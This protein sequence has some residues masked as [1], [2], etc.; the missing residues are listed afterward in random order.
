MKI[1]FVNYGFFGNNSYYHIEGFA[2]H[3]S[4]RGH[5]VGVIADGA[6]SESLPGVAMGSFEQAARGGLD[7]GL[8]ALLGDCETILHAWTPREPVR[9]FVEPLA[10]AGLRYV[11]HLEDDELLVTASQL[12]VAAGALMRMTPAQVDARLPNHLTHPHKLQGFLGRASGITVIVEPLLK[13][14][15]PASPVHLLE[16]G[17][18]SAMFAPKLDPQERTHRRKELGIDPE[19]VLLVYHGNVHEAVQRDI[20]SLY[21]A[22]KILRRQ[23]RDVRLL[24]TGM[25]ECVTSTSTSYRMSSGVTH[26][27]RLPRAELPALLDLADIYVQSGWLNGFNLARF[28]SKLPEFFAM[29]RPVVLP[30][31]NLGLQVRDGH[32]AIVLQ[33]GGAAEIVR[34]VERLI[35]DPDLA[36]DMGQA[37]RQ[38]ALAQLSWEEKT[39]GLEAFYASLASEG[40][41]DHRPP[42]GSPGSET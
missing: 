36:R 17:V 7:A 6:P 1:V 32:D 24:R 8:S 2:H 23:G 5:Q 20:F 42:G 30:K 19:T 34:C 28:P 12:N 29:A 13:Y 35:A 31:A 21:T 33:Q 37:G 27:G 39:S 38:F 40:G 25:S 10:A 4:A 26:L 14:A 16:P 11:V 41:V 18:D 3:L 22:V 9:R 15:P